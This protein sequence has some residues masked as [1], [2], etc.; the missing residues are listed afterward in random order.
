MFIPE[1]DGYNF[2]TSIYFVEFGHTHIMM[3]RTNL[4]QNTQ[5]L[6]ILLHVKKTFST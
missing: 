4:L 1:L 2:C 5:Q 3:F 6:I